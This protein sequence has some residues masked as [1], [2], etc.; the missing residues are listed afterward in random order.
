VTLYK[1][2]GGG[3]GALGAGS[4]ISEET[5]QQMSSRTHWGDLLAVREQHEIAQAAATARST[6]VGGA[7]AVVEAPV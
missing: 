4:M 3:W 6:T 2:L 1:G 7:L 5:A